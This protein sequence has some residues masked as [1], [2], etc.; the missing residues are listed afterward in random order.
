MPSSVGWATVGAVV[1]SVWAWEASPP[2]V[3]GA[4]VPQA[5]IRTVTKIARLST[6]LNLRLL[7]VVLL[8]IA[9]LLPMYYVFLIY[10]C[11]KVFKT[12]QISPIY[13]CSRYQR[14]HQFII[15]SI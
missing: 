15:D 2:P 1:G 6:H 11:E 7:A 8:V 9:N 3:G 12:L 13:I 14:C 4:A 10:N 5:T